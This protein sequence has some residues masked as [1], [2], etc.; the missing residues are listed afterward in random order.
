[1][2]SFNEALDRHITGDYGE[3]QIVA[4]ICATCGKIKCDCQ[5]NTCPFTSP[6]FVKYCKQNCALWYGGRCAFVAIADKLND[7]RGGE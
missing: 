2:R 3:D 5:K 7:L 6:E 4:K 1:M